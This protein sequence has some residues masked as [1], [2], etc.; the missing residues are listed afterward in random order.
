MAADAWQQAT[1]NNFFWLFKI[2]A[3]SQIPLLGCNSPNLVGD[4]AQTLAQ[5]PLRIMYRTPT[6]TYKLDEINGSLRFQI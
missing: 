5:F 3:H 6:D 1:H 2:Q 4:S